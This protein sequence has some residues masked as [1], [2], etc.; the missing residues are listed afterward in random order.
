[1]TDWLEVQLRLKLPEQ[2]GR[3]TP[4]LP[5]GGYYAPHFR[6][7]PG[8]EFLGVAF[9]DG[10]PEIVPGADATVTVA[11]IYDVDYS[12]LQPGASFEL[13]EGLTV[14]GTGSV[15]RRWTE[16]RDWRTGPSA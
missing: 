16:A 9:T 4:V 10:P 5:R 11:L 15:L 14:I 12:A 3:K 6:V 13:F 1:M 8:S 7:T 2:S